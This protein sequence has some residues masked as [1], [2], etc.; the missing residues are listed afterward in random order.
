MWQVDEWVVH[1]WKWAFI[2]IHFC[3]SVQMCQDLRVHLWQYC[4][5]SLVC[6]MFDYILCNWT[7]GM[8]DYHRMWFTTSASSQLMVWTFSIVCSATADWVASRD[9]GLSCALWGVALISCWS[10]QCRHL[11]SFH[12]GSCRLCP[13]SAVLELT[14]QIWRISWS[15]ALEPCMSNTD[16]R[17]VSKST[18]QL[19]YHLCLS[20]WPTWW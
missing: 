6:Q 1:C 16:G 3:C 20:P 19:W 18:L 17:C 14:R 9:S 8:W 10:D 12:S 5:I 4:R 15:F 7:S 2:S 13:F 11:E